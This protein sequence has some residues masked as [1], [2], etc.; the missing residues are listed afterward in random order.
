MVNNEDAEAQRQ[1]SQEVKYLTTNK[2]E[3]FSLISVPLPTMLGV[4]G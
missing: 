2:S 3:K 4:V 1:A